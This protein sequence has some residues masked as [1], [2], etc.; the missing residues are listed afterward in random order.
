MDNL[1]L[2]YIGDTRGSMKVVNRACK[3][4]INITLKRKIYKQ[5]QA[6][7]EMKRIQLYEQKV[8]F[9]IEKFITGNVL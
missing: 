4:R 2:K 5:I 1:R 6:V 7:A 9:D 8:I 3:I